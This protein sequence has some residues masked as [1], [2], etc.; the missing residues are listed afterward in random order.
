MS[1]IHKGVR[2]TFEN[3]ADGKK[4]VFQHEEG[5]STS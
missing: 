3:E 5:L 4:E 2:V 1:Y